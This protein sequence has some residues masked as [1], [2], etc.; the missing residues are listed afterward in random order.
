MGHRLAALILFIW[1]IS[2]LIKVLKNYKHSRIMYWGWIITTSLI[3]LQVLFGALVIINGTNLGI[4]ANIT[5]F[6]ALMHALVI[7]CY[8]GMLSYYVLLS[9][10]SAKQK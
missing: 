9:S 2:F 4:D 5:L 10:R 6:V 8:F 3:I 1:T 7:T